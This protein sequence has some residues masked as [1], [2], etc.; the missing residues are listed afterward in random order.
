MEYFYRKLLKFQ[1]ELIWG[2]ATAMYTFSKFLKDKQLD[3]NSLNIK[4]IITT[5]DLLYDHVRE[6][7]NS[8]FNCP[9]ANHYA[10]RD[11]GVIAGECPKGNMHIHAENVIVESINSELIITHLENYVMP[12]IRYRI[13]DIGI[14]SEELCPCGRGLPLLKSLEGRTND[15]LLTPS[16][17]SVHSL[18]MV[19]I[20]RDIKNIKQ[21][22]VVQEERDRLVIKIVKESNFAEV[23]AV[24][25]IRKIKE[26]MGKEINI[27]FEFVNEIPKEP[28]GKFKWVVSNV[29]KNNN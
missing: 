21:F 11:A 26:L 6:F 23:D 8:V 18:S 1:P 20:M 14:L 13:G 27:F 28:S 9:V 19:Y 24:Y 3:T 16:D 25:I 4:V 2:Y 5:G 12:F 15:I 29:R 7:I 10:A 22:K 17:K